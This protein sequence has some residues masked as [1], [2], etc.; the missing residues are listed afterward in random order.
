[1]VGFLE[2]PFRQTKYGMLGLT[3]GIFA[4]AMALAA[5]LSLGWARSIF[6]PVERMTRTMQLVQSGEGGARVGVLAQHDELGTL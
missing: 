2:T 5:W 6:Q 1:Y 4:A 3:I